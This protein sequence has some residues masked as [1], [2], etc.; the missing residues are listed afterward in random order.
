MRSNEAPVRILMFKKI[1]LPDGSVKEEPI[2]Q[3]SESSYYD[4]MRWFIK[5]FKNSLSHNLS[6]INELRRRNPDQLA[7]EYFNKNENKENKKPFVKFKHKDTNYEVIY[8]HEEESEMLSIKRIDKDGSIDS[9]MLFAGKPKYDGVDAKN[10]GQIIWTRSVDEYKQTEDIY[11]DRNVS[12]HRYFETFY[13]DM[14][15]RAVA[16]KILGEL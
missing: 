11:K 7:V 13:N 3:F 1:S 6:F 2:F 9:I 4:S 10:E 16:N 5:G 15:S 12:Y 8:S 14:K